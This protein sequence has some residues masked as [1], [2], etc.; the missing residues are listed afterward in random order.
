MEGRRMATNN[1]LSKVTTDWQMKRKKLGVLIFFMFD[2]HVQV[3]KSALCLVS[4]TKEKFISS[5]VAMEVVNRL[6]R[7]QNN[8]ELIGENRK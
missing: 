8:E 2:D 7:A 6:S 1:H 5:E 3:G 4:Q